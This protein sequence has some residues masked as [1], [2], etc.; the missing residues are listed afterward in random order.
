MEPGDYVE[1]LGPS[2]ADPHELFEHFERRSLAGRTC[3]VLA[4]TR[5][6]VERGTVIM[7]ED[8]AIIRGFPSIPRVLVL[9]PGIAT[10]FRDSSTVSVEEKLDGYNARI[11]HIAEP[12]AFT[13]SGLVCPYT[14][15]L[16]RERLSLSSFFASF[17]DAMLCAE[18][19]GPESPYTPTAY[20]DIDTI[21]VRVFD[22]RHRETGEPLPVE[23][24][25]SR[26]AECGFPQ[27]RWFGT[28]RLDAAP[29][30]IRS[31]I[32]T[33]DAANREGVVV[34]SAN[35]QSMLKYTTAAQH[36]EEL[37]YAF[38]YPFDYGQDFLFSRVTRDAFQAV[39]FDA[40][41]DA[42]RE[43]A[44]ALGESILLPMVDT[45]EAVDADEP[46]G[47]R[48]T[49]RGDSATVSALL[50]HLEAQSLTLEIQTDDEQDAERLVEFIKVARATRDRIQHYLAGGTPDD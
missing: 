30:V 44:H 15:E 37:A 25:R 23:A 39:E 17:P 47:Q 10:Y 11:V 36:H 12:L 27:P 3:Y 16:V 13:R 35:G 21:D 9:D 42:L 18:V 29:A 1:R 7:P 8:D 28:P 2:V 5:H 50:D 48:H 31:A 45:I 38:S 19:I 43:R 34:R 22:I 41:D 32:E 20:D 6:G 14:T 24:R 49:V 26:A 40:D 46:I 4:A 33:L